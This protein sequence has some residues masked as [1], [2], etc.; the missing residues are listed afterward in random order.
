MRPFWELH[1]SFLE[2]YHVCLFTCTPYFSCVQSS[3]WMCCRANTHHLCGLQRRFVGNLERP[4]QYHAF[5]ILCISNF[6][7]LDKYLAYALGSFWN[8]AMNCAKIWILGQG[9]RARPCSKGPYNWRNNFL[10]EL[11]HCA[12]DVLDGPQRMPKRKWLFSST[13]SNV[14]A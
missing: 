14:S 1:I 5:T 4:V 13:V 9:E 3:N 7:P 8:V 6:R 10:E 11:C 12:L 2:D